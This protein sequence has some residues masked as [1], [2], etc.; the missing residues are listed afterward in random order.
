MK[1]TI[2]S[3]LILGIGIFS[4]LVAT[5]IFHTSIPLL[6]VGFYTLGLGTFMFFVDMSN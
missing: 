3:I 1:I 6:C 4:I 2:H 5:F